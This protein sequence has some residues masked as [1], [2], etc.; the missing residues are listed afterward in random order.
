MQARHQGSVDRDPR[1]DIADPIGV[2]VVDD[3]AIEQVAVA[4]GDAGGTDLEAEFAH[5]LRGWALD[6]LPAD[7]WRHRDDR[8]ATRLDRMAH[9]RD[10]QDRLAAYEGSGREE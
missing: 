8:S 9:A 5:H 7:D 10:R 4:C 3:I 2:G 1:A 6:G